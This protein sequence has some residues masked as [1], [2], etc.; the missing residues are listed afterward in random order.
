VIEISKA[1]EGVKYLINRNPRNLERLRI[2]YKPKGYF[3]EKPGRS[4]WHKLV[5]KSTSQGVTAQIIHF[6][7]GPVLEASTNE[8]SIRKH[9][10]QST[11]TSAYINLARVFAQRCLASGLTEMTCTLDPAPNTKVDKFLKTLENEGVRLKEADQYTAPRPWDLMRPEK[12]WE[13]TE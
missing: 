4:F 1:E 2:A 12:P 13:V 11:D 7:N 9:L 6:E 3:L 5:L 8:W 10:Y